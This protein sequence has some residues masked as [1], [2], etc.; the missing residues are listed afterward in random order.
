VNN[1]F[2]QP[3]S[4]VL[5]DYMA[6]GTLDHQ[7]MNQLTALA[8]QLNL[9]VV[10][11]ISVHQTCLAQARTP[12]DFSRAASFCSLQIEAL[13][14]R[15]FSFTDVPHSQLRAILAELDDVVTLADKDC[16]ISYVNPAAERLTGY[17]VDRLIGN[18]SQQFV[19][20][21]DAERANRE[22][23]EQAAQTDRLRTSP[24]RIVTA[25][26][27]V[28][29]VESSVR[30]LRDHSGAILGTLSVDRDMTSHINRQQELKTSEQRYRALFEKSHD[31]ILLLDLEGYCIGCNQAAFELLQYG[32][33]DLI[34]CHYSDVNYLQSYDDAA[35][36]HQRL[37]AGEDLPSYEQ[38]FIRKDGSIVYCEVST[39]LVR[40][41]EGK[42]LHI[43]HIIHDVTRTRQLLDSLEESRYFIDQVA[44]AVPDT[45]Y[46]MDF[47]TRQT[48]YTNRSLGSTLGYEQMDLNEQNL[49]ATIHP[50]DL[51]RNLMGNDRLQG[52]GDETSAVETQFR[53]R[54]SKGFYEW[55]NIRELVFKRDQAGNVKQVIGVA[56]KFTR[57]KIAEDALKLNQRAVEASP[58]G[59]VITDA[60]DPQMPILYINPAFSFI[61]GYSEEETLGR[62]CRF[63]QGTDRDQPALTELRQ[64]IR[65]DR[66]CTVVLRNYRR[67][68][69]LFWNELRISPIYDP[70]NKLINYVGIMVDI[71]E[72]IHT[73]QQLEQALAV[74]Q[75]ANQFKNYFL[76]MASHEFRT[77]ITVIR[78]STQTLRDYYER[79][80][81]D[82]RRKRFE[83][84]DAQIT[85]I[86]FMLDDVLTLGKLDS[87]NVQVNR[88]EFEFNEWLRTFIDDFM[89]TKPTHEILTSYTVP[90]TVTADK[91]LI[92]QIV[93]NLITNAIKY[94]P[95][96]DLVELSVERHA[97]SIRLI[98]RDHG[99]GIPARDLGKLFREFQR[100]S[101]VGDIPGTG[102]GLAIVK[103]AI[104]LHHGSI[105]IDSRVGQGTEI[106]VDLPI[107][108]GG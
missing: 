54:H 55:I 42:P 61:T 98:V 5:L 43:Q 50:D 81:A 49:L 15:V 66:E 16:I 20:P 44:R 87:P 101:N 62:N 67:N 38:T 6:T 13:Q 28:R 51:A 48:L 94:S 22:Y 35:L 4:A 7:R 105:S 69:E 58:V 106:T 75:D 63:L 8:R 27:S 1:I 78:S 47:E 71:T 93:S 34:G 45:I 70:Q 41:D 72:T 83:N 23:Y 96:V 97:D 10:D 33:G 30:I 2:E 84:I 95:D 19:V 80:D 60:T 99:I 57:R 40:D 90:I 59:I 88:E 39:A 24:Y 26:G 77:P 85:R 11:L 82:Q 56:Q 9:Q 64:A 46:V 102:L 18:H 31:A 65:E 104:N 103:R 86:S 53:I 107:I 73:R 3:Y 89:L 76:S 108:A 100:A 79:M 29:W 91:Q 37:L 17:P 68:G 14:D 92:R 36:I 12:Q 52:L 32:A 21:E 25:D 74:A